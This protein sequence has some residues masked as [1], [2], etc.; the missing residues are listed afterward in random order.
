MLAEGAVSFGT[1][2]W[3]KAVGDWQQIDAVAALLHLAEEI[4]PEPWYVLDGDGEQVGPM[5]R[6]GLREL[7]SAGK[8]GDESAVWS[9]MLGSWEQLDSVAAL[10]SLRG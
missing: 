8:I 1:P 10:A 5:G 3:C 7:L 2:V 6:D 4:C 9:K